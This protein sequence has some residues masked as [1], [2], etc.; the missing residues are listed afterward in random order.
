MKDEKQMVMIKSKELLSVLKFRDMI[1]G[2]QTRGKGH[3]HWQNIKATKGAKDAQKAAVAG[4][5]AK[6]IAVAVKEGG[7][8]DPKL[9]K[10]LAKVMEEGLSA[11]V[12]KARIQDMV[13]NALAK[14]KSMENGLLF[15]LGPMG[16]TFI[17]EVYTD[18]MM[19]TRQVIG[20]QLKR[21]GGSLHNETGR[22]MFDEKG[23][24][25]VS[26]TAA[27]E[28]VNMDKYLEVAIEAGAED[29]IVTEDENTD[30]EKIKV[31]KFHCDPFQVNA[32][33]KEIESHDLEVSSA[34]T[35]FLPLSWVTLQGKELS[36]AQHIYERLSEQEDVVRIFD[37]VNTPEE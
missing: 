25:T 20:A 1:G 28:P 2:I 31:L 17:M 4:R 12:T 24:I 5:V 19:R 7:G 29:V 30:G 15:A 9:N 14:N 22:Q 35:E 16:C 27:M 11:G 26:V 10:Q 6:F 3:S 34:E 33:K 21:A 32:V 8:G 37:N 36:V 23:I 18:N 13:A